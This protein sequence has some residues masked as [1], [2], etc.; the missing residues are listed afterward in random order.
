MWLRSTHQGD[1]SP[2]NSPEAAVMAPSLFAWQVRGAPLHLTAPCSG[3]R[4]RKRA[5]RRI[6]DGAKRLPDV[7]KGL[8]RRRDELLFRSEKIVPGAQ[9]L[10][11]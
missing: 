3:K 5:R 7:E 9:K 11:A 6:E 10:L 8:R 2:G 1:L 4:M